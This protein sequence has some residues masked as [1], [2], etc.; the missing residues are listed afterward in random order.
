MSDVLNASA[1]TP[2][3]DAEPRDTIPDDP[4]L[5]QAVREYLKELES[6]QRPDRRRWLERY[7]DLADALGQCLDGL[8]LVHR[9]A[10]WQVLC[11]AIRRGFW[12]M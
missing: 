12:G 7:P 3:A 4:R 10:L 8:E 9:A 11:R 6:G 5:A 1:H 2:P